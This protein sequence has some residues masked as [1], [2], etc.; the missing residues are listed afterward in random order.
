LSRSSLNFGVVRSGAQITSQTPPQAIM[1]TQH[2][3]ATMTWTVSSSAPW[4]R[5]SVASGTG[6]G[7]FTLNIDGAALPQSGNLDATVMVSSS[8]AAT[9]P[10][11]IQ[12]RL[13]QLAAGA[14]AGPYGSFDTPAADATVVG[15]I[16]VTGWALDDVAVNKV[17]IWRDGVNS[18]PVA[19]NGKVFIGHAVFVAGAR[20]DVEG[21]SGDKPLSYRAGW[22]YLLLTNVL[23]DIPAG[24]P[25]GGNGTF[26]LYAYASDIEGHQ[27]ALGSKRITLANGSATKPFGTLDTPG[28]GEVIGGTSYTSFGWALSPRSVIPADGSTIDVYI[29][30]VKMGHPTY[31]NNRADIA[32]AFPHYANSTGAIGYLTFDTSRLTNGVHTIGWVAADAAG[33]AEG[34]GSRFFTVFNGA[35]SGLTAGMNAMTAAVGSQTGQAAAALADVPLANQALEVRR[36]VA[37]G[38]ALKVAMPE[39]HGSIALRSAELEQVELRLVNEFTERG[40]TFEG[41][42]VVAGQ[43]RPLP[44]GSALDGATGVF[45]WQPGP[46]FVGE[47]DFVFV[48]TGAEGS[49]AKVPVRVTIAP[50]F[51][52]RQ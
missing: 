1:I 10:Q 19:A 20:P 37:P 7:A 49:K 50:K 29:D 45:T 38:S 27:T 40:G 30:G 9:D 15:A 4:L 21:M 52:K 35:A 44:S 39:Y 6:S 28:Q 5:P 34:L 32:G 22:G 14:T 46:G 2:S 23:P 47:Y 12:V 51:A 13:M 11:L 3:G 18:E 42:L 25:S 17:E 31:N 36:A 16:A 8:G 26:T 41:Y 33:N 48:R 43:L 24:K